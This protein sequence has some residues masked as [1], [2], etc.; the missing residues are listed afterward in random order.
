MIPHSLNAIP[1]TM[2]WTLYHRAAESLRP[3]AIFKDEAAEQVF[4]QLEFDFLH[5][6][7]PP[8]GSIAARTRMYDD[9]VS[10][11]L[12]AHPGGVVVELGCG[13]ET[14]SLRLREYG[15]PWTLI[16][17]PESLRWRQQLIQDPPD[18]RQIACDCFKL[19]EWTPQ[20]NS[21]APVLVTAQGL[22]MYFPQDKVA[23]LLA[24]ILATFNDVELIF[25][26]LPHWISLWTTSA[27]GFWKTPYYR[28]PPMPWGV[29]P[30]QIGPLV[31]SWT[32]RPMQVESYPIQTMRPLPP[33]WWE[34]VGSMPLLQDQL[35]AV[36]H[37]KPLK[38]L[39]PQ[40][41]LATRRTRRQK[42]PKN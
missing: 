7:G 9:L 27:L 22:L 39:K 13:L 18:A 34:W 2:L 17:L 1:H 3:D 33:A 11:W 37:V 23:Q 15:N 19:H 21:D 6:F 42:R 8:D 14:Q 30:S 12:T 5:H 16:D 26:I 40:K 10:T 38:P 31:Q 32:A 35:P 20:I 41:S 24:G 25:D 29:L 36:V 4:A 28:V